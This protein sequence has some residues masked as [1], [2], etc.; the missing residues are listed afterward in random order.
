ME[1]ARVCIATA[2]RSERGLIEPLIPE[3][4][5]SGKF[6]VELLELPLSFKGAFE[7]VE[8]YL[9]THEKPS[10]AFCS[11][12]RVEML[13]ACLAFFL[14]NIPIV[15][16]YSG[17]S[18]GGNI[19]DEIVGMM[20]ALCS[21]LHLCHDEMAADVLRQM[22]IE[23]WR[24]KVVGSIA[25]DNVELDTGKVPNEPYDLVLINPDTISA[26]KTRNDIRKALSLI[27]K[28]AVIIYPNED[29]FREIIIEEIENYR[30]WESHKPHV[31]YKTIERS[32]F[33]ALI[34]HAQR[35]ITNSSSEFFEA[36]YFGTY[37]VHI[38]ERN[39]NRKVGK[40]VPGAVKKIIEILEKLEINEKFLRKKLTWEKF[41]S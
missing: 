9:R 17:S 7:C 6:E 22:G 16:L 3:F 18:I 12:D 31:I 28:F 40:I 41:F 1:K 13:S 21:H 35:F 14:N 11:F 29:R 39:K 20:I 27:D 15:H 26:E 4:L 24:I 34:K 36:P 19:H 23:D 5:K 2:S 32:Q 30:N 33:L 37:C 38:G 8:E 25:F 10:L